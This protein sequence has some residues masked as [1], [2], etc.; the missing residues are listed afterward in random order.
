[1]E[2]IKDW[3]DDHGTLSFIIMLLLLCICINSISNFCGKTYKKFYPNKCP[4]DY[5][6]TEFQSICRD[7]AVSEDDSRVSYLFFDDKR[8]AVGCFMLLVNRLDSHYANGKFRHW[9]V[10]NKE[11]IYQCYD[12]DKNLIAVRLS[13]HKGAFWSGFGG[14]DERKPFYELQFYVEGN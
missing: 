5:A 12:R 4:S 13:K 8:E 6:I 3:I 10:L 1:M 2:R 11:R 7:Y 9:Y 14:W